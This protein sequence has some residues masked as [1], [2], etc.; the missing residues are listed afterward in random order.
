MFSFFIYV[1]LFYSVKYK[2]YLASNITWHVISSRPSDLAR[3]KKFLCGG[4]SPNATV[5][6]VFLKNKSF[7]VRVLHTS[8]LYCIHYLPILLI[9]PLTSSH[10]NDFL[11]K[12]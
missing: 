8:Y 1:I 12:F 11:E 6:R 7:S 4:H 2:Y 5:K 10:F 9:R 3:K